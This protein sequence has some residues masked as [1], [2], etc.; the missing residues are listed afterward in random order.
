VKGNYPTFPA[1]GRAQKNKI[2]GN[3]GS[4]RGR[5]KSLAFGRL[6]EEGEVG[7][8]DTANSLFSHADDLHLPSL[9]SPLKD[10]KT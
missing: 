6:S 10:L 4:G 1:A 7:G 9:N 5:V 3:W 2:R 8:G